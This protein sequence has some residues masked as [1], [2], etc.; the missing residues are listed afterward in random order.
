[1]EAPG[2]SFVA[3]QD[4]AGGGDTSAFAYR[5]GDLVHESLVEPAGP[6]RLGIDVA[7]REGAK[8]DRPAKSA[9]QA[10]WAAYAVSMGASADDVAEM[11]RSALIKA[12]GEDAS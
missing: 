2:M 11:T 5:V 8:I 12:Y 6:Y 3:L 4:I 7:A 10:A 9:S 1:M